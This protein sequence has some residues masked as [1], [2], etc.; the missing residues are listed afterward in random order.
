M[1]TQ[2]K[3]RIKCEKSVDVNGKYDIILYSA[4]ENTQTVV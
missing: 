1:E 4:I 3:K 2:R